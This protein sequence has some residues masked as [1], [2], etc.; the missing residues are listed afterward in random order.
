[1][2]TVTGHYVFNGYRDRAPGA[3]TNMIDTLQWESLACR[4]TKAIMIL[5]YTINGGFSRGTNNHAI[6]I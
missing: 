2:T 4:R 6:P 1:M 5:L 3:V